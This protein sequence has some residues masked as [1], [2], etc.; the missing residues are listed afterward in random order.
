MIQ[1]RGYPDIGVKPVENL[2][3]FSRVITLLIIYVCR[4]GAHMR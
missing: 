2:A 3:D 1:N 4:A